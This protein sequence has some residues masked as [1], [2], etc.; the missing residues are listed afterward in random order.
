MDL[1][2][3]GRLSELSLSH[4]FRCLYSVSRAPLGDLGQAFDGARLNGAGAAR[5]K[6]SY[7]Q[8]VPHLKREMLLL[9]DYLLELPICAPCTLMADATGRNL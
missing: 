1:C 6:L 8:L 9:H 5:E 7:I 4:F 3:L 2:K